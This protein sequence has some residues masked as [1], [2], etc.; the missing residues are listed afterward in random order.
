M[1]FH[2]LVVK[3]RM[4]NF[5]IRKMR[6]HYN[7]R[8]RF[9]WLLMMVYLPML[10]A[11]TFHYHTAAEGDSAAAYCSDCNHHVH[12]DGHLATSQGFTQECPICHLQ[13]LPY[14]VPTI[15]HIA[16][17]VAMVHVAFSMSCL[18]VK[19]RQGDIQST[20]APP[21]LLTLLFFGFLIQTYWL[22]RYFVVA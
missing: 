14:V 5:A 8:T 6:N 21:V 1:I 3:M 18:F 15:V 4:G 17:F 20:R 19:T 22:S 11:I 13:S 9:A 16:A 7:R 10:L 12:H 2:C